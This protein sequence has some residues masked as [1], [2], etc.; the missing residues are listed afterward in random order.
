MKGSL[1]LKRPSVYHSLV[2]LGWRVFTVP[3]WK[4]IGEGGMGKTGMESPWMWACR[5]L[6]LFLEL[7]PGLGFMFPRDTA[8]RDRPL[9]GRVLPDLEEQ[10]LS[11]RKKTPTMSQHLFHTNVSKHLY[12]KK[13]L[14]WGRGESFIP[15]HLYPFSLCAQLFKCWWRV[16]VLF[17][18]HHE[19]VLELFK[20]TFTFWTNFQILKGFISHLLSGNFASLPFYK[21]KDFISCCDLFRS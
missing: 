15:N 20:S 3:G 18:M 5:L 2:R 11:R 6:E 4:T 10:I 17:F 8:Q 7:P 9:Q 12:T 19:K 21:I 1:C 14:G 13:D 16:R